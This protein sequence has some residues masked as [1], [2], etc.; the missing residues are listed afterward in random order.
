[1]HFCRVTHKVIIGAHKNRSVVHKDVTRDLGIKKP[2]L[3][4]FV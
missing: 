2:P 4:G 3:G 1:M